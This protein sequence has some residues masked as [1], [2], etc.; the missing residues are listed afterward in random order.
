MLL[1]H[2]SQRL[3]NLLCLECA[4]LKVLCTHTFMNVSE[5]MQFGL[6]SPLDRVEQ[7]HAP[8]TLHLFRNPVQE[9]CKGKIMSLWLCVTCF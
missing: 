5:H 4:C 9:T 6:D 1:T 8:D 2:D 3:E 7:L